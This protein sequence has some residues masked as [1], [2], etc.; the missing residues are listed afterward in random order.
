MIYKGS[1]HATRFPNQH[2]LA[3]EIEGKGTYQSGQGR[4][5]LKRRDANVVARMVEI[6]TQGKIER[7]S[8]KRN[9]SH[10]DN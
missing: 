10:V 5:I 3:Q 6:A 1:Q 8:S 2:P 9:Q 4:E 7:R